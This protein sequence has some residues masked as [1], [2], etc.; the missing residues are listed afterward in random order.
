MSLPR[1]SLRKLIAMIA[2]AAVDCLMLRWAWAGSE[3]ISWANMI[4]LPMANILLIL[5]ARPRAFREG[6]RLREDRVGFQILGWF[7]MAG[8][9]CLFLG[10]PQ[11]F[12]KFVNFFEPVGRAWFDT[13]IY[14]N[15]TPQS[16]TRL[17]IFWCAEISLLVT[18][19]TVCTLTQL[20][21][22]RA[23]VW[24]ASRGADRPLQKIR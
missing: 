16:A 9:L 15:A 4:A 10:F 13:D 12:V 3:L 22:A 23:G 7:I 5:A 21:I 24:L 11:V 8:A 1:V 14:R 18:V 2:L 19:S 17:R 20:L 6:G